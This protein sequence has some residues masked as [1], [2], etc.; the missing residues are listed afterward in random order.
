MKCKY[1]HNDIIF[2]H[3]GILSFCDERCRKLY[4]STVRAKKRPP[5]AILAPKSE[6]EGGSLPQ[7]KIDEFGG[8]DWYKLMKQLCCNFDTKN[9]EGYCVTLFSPCNGFVR[10]CSE[11]EVGLSLRAH[12]ISKTN[13]KD[14]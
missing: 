12:H 4:N 6:N 1:C 10:K 7:K 11:C 8:L 2:T 3:K 5:E 9:K 14:K 13:K